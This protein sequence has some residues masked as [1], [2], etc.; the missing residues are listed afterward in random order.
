MKFLSYIPIGF[1]RAYQFI[2]SPL[3]PMSCRYW[4]SCSQYACEVLARHGVA[5]GGWLTLVRVLRCQPWGG[6]GYDPVPE[7]FQPW[8][9]VTQRGMRAAGQ[10]DHRCPGH[11]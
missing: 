2:L 5:R 4:P 9:G 8:L 7:R 10:R 1:I 11:S 3:L 6:A